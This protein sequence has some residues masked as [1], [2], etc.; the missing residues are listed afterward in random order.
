MSFLTSILPLRSIS[1]SYHLPKCHSVIATIAIPPSDPLSQCHP[2]PPFFPL[3]VSFCHLTP[4]LSVI[5][6]SLESSLGIIL[7]LPLVAFRHPKPSLSFYAVIVTPP[8][9]SFR[10]PYPSVACHSII[11]YPLSQCQ[12][13]TPVPLVPLRHL[14]PPLCSV[15]PSP[16]SFPLI[17]SFHRLYLSLSVVPSPNP[18]LLCHLH[19]HV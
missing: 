2:S 16:S 4:S 7:S 3:V 8:L 15:I 13:V 14:I 12:S 19:K 18:S 17:V 11:V 6:P 9:V 5:P 1:S 10:H